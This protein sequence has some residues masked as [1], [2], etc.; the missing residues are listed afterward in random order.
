MIYC[1]TKGLFLTTDC[2]NYR[3][4]RLVTRHYRVCA[5]GV[6]G[7]AAFNIF[8]RLAITAVSD[9]D[10]ARY[11]VAASEMLRSHSHLIATYAG[12]AEFWNLKPPL[13]YWLLELSY[14]L[15]GPT[16]LSLRLPSALAALAVVGATMQTC[17]RWHNR[18]TA[19]LAGLIIATCFGFLSHHGARSGDLDAVLTL[20]VLVGTA[21]VPQL[22]R[23]SVSRLIWAVMISLG[24]LLKSFA[25]LPLLVVS[26]AHLWLTGEARQQKLRDWLPAAAVIGL[27]IGGWI[28][29][30]SIADG[31]TYFVMRMIREDLFARSTSAIDRGSYVPWDYVGVM[32]DRLAPWPIV[33][34]LSWLCARRLQ[35][36]SRPK[37]TQLLLLWAL[38][39][40]AMFSIA[41]THHHWYMDPSYPAWAMIAA[42]GCL[43][44]MR[45]VPPQLPRQLVASLIL[46]AFIGCELRF[47]LRVDR[48]AL[49]HSQRFLLSLK[50]LPMAPQQ[51]VC[52]L[53][54]LSH[55]ERF[56]LEVI[57]RLKVEEIS[58]LWDLSCGNA[59]NALLLSRN[60]SSRN[61]PRTDV[62]R[63][64]Q[65]ILENADYQLLRPLDEISSILLHNR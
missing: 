48:D 27:S 58:P 60:D 38:V 7:L 31:L 12:R 41:H 10:E 15:F 42:A 4:G 16:L 26:A 56:I 45:S 33:A 19:L 24:F 54:P 21:Q 63:Y 51:R 18:R 44:L 36:H 62:P 53:F 37:Q 25:I 23:S 2:W 22:G 50:T 14:Q 65:A 40:L 13:G 29:A 32:F 6:L 47:A 49:T 28:I 8:W 3:L 59:N 9:Y 57:D 20:I 30:R 52:A 35:S 11:G 46:L 43:A 5:F 17:R 39:P 55:S 1:K 61:L 64:A 34:L